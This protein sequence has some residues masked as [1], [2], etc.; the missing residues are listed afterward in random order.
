VTDERAHSGRHSLKWDISEV[1][2]A[3]PGWVVVNVGFPDDTVKRLQGKRVK[4]GCWYMLG[5]G[6]AMP[7]LVV[8]S[9]DR[10]GR[11]GGFVCLGGIEDAAVWNHFEAEGRLGRDL[12][13]LDI[14]IACPIPD[15]ATA[16]NSYFFMDDV[17]LEAIEEPPLAVSTPLDEYYLGEMIP[18][19]VSAAS[20]SGEVKVQFTRGDRVIAEQAGTSVKGEFE[21]RRLRPGIY[22]L[23]ASCN[24]G[25]ATVTA[26]KQIIVALDPFGW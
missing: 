23:R 20:G 9:Q 2:D 3:G 15:T 19:M 12:V 7:E 14:H 8:R 13:G 25:G 4:V 18:W 6:T 17:S 5:A 11:N 21:T 10:E 22:T 1:A 16:R 24:T 26:H